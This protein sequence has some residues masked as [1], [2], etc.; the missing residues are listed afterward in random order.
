MTTLIKFKDLLAADGLTTC[1][2][3]VR[4]DKTRKI[5]EVDGQHFAFTGSMSNLIAKANQAILAVKLY[6]KGEVVSNRSFEEHDAC[7]ARVNGGFYTIEREDG[8]LLVC[9]VTEKYAAFGHGA[10]IALGALVATE[11]LDKAIAI[12]SDLD[13]Y[14]GGKWVIV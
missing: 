9:K 10:D 12:V 13:V 11:S 14:T 1:H 6:H 2:G 4:D 7:L 3:I 8:R 5:V